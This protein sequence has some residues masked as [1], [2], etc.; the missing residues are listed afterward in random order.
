MDDGSRHRTDGGWPYGAGPVFFRPA[1]PPAVRRRR[2]RFCLAGAVIALALV[3]P[4]Y[5]LVA[6]YEP[7]IFGLPFFFAWV[8]AALIAMFV[9]LLLLFRHEADGAAEDG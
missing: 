5:P 9:N 7:Q 6:T 2:R 8:V 4:F 1:T 3:W